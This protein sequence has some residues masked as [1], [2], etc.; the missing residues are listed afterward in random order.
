MFRGEA[1][2]MV[3]AGDIVDSR[4]VSVSFKAIEGVSTPCTIS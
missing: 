3:G 4:C 1:I 2:G